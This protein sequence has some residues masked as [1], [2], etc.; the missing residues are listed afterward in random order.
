[1]TDAENFVVDVARIA[2]STI[3]DGQHVI[4]VSLII[5]LFEKHFDMKDILS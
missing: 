4:D 2:R 1:M 5:D 3:D